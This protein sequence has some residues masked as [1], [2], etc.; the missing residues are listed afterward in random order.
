MSGYKTD[1]SRLARVA[2]AVSVGF[3]LLQPVAAQKQK[4]SPPPG[5]QAIGAMALRHIQARVAGIDPVHNSVTLRDPRGEMAVIEVNPDVADIT[6]L[7]V[8]DRVNIAYRSAILIH[9]DKVASSGIRAR[10]ETEVVQPASGGVVTS[11]RSVEVSATVLVV[12]RKH[13]QVTLR[14]PIQTEVFDVAPDISLGNLKV[15]D[16]VRAVFV[17]AVAVSVAREGAAPE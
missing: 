9:L 11:T 8:G 15:G 16:S 17:S 1:A 6:K 3:L 4:A 2:L 12:D 5:R 7:E 13:R 14:G 10:V